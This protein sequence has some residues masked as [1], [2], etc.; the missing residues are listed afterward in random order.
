MSNN[1]GVMKFPFADTI[2]GTIMSFD[3]EARCFVMRTSD[4]RDFHVK[5]TA[6]T[7]AEMVRNLGEAYADCTGDMKDL[8]EEGTFLYAHGIFYPES[9]EWTF[10]AK[11]LLF[12]GRDAGDFRF[13]EQDWWIR[14]GR[15][16]ACPCARQRATR[17]SP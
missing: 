7:F 3:W 10:E 2:A 14:H 16:Q 15:R 11:H 1:P 5:L 6:T 17:P 4:D 9:G 8:L 12:L 13:E